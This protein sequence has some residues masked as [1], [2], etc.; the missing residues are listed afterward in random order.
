LLV[1]T[2][3]VEPDHFDKPRAL[4]GGFATGGKDLPVPRYALELVFSPVLEVKS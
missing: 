1:V 4:P 3:Q 2:P